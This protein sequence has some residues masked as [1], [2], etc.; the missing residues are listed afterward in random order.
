M[1]PKFNLLDW[2]MV[3]APRY[4]VLAMMATIFLTVPTTSMSL[5]ST[6]SMGGRVLHDY[7]GSLKPE[8]VEALVRGASYN[9][10]SHKDF[11]LVERDEDEEDDV[12]NIKLPKIVDV[13]DN[14]KC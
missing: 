4:P 3:N 9:K 10:G 14:N 7:M 13:G 12:E 11:N 1:D 8:M 6:F 2:W 5:D